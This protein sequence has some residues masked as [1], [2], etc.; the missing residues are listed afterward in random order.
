MTENEFMLYYNPQTMDEANKMINGLRSNLRR[1]IEIAR[2]FHAH[3]QAYMDNDEGD[4]FCRRSNDLR[5]ELIKME[6]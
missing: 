4:F 5:D 2:W 3:E 1:A 6:R